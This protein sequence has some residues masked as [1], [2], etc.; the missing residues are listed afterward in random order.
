MSQGAGLVGRVLAGEQR[1]VARMITLIENGDPDAGTMVAE[2]FPHT[3]RADVIGVT[4]PPGAGKSTLVGAMVEVW[5][6]RGR[7]VAVL[8]I[9]PSSPFTGGALLGDRIRMGS[10]TGDAGVYVR[11]MANRAHLG[12]LAEA[13]PA[14][15]RVL[16]AMGMDVVVVETVGVGQSEVAIAD[17]ADCTLLVTMP[18]GGD[19]IQAMKAGVLE[20]G[21]VFV[22]NKS[23][24]DGALST[25]RELTAMVRMHDH[26]SRPSV[27]L[28]RADVGEGVE[29]VVESIEAFLHARRESGQ[30]DQRRLRHLE[31]ETL[32]LIGIQAR[33]RTM[34]VLDPAAI[35][36]FAEALRSRRL[37]PATVAARALARVAVNP[38]ASGPLAGR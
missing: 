10:L 15:I 7:T 26:T 11:S 9:D 22:V 34:A 32:E 25:Q 35:A 18:G 17:T 23:D 16:D 1:A 5:R 20:I 19:G 6:R 29:Q 33:R 14:A 37:D 36:E 21:D 2:L 30:F 28:T 27:L 38:A 13:T 4:G 24:R 31:R 3:G 12:G 8:A